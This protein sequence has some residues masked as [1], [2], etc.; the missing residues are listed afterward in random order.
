MGIK[1]LVGRKIPY[2]NLFNY[3][4][5]ELDIYEDGT[6]GSANYEI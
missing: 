3:V 2:R 1:H 4:I 5:D 6:M